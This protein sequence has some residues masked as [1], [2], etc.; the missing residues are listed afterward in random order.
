MFILLYSALTVIGRRLKH[1]SGQRRLYR[2]GFNGQSESNYWI[3][4]PV[5]VISFVL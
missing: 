2:L 5:V 4:Q 3:S 1:L